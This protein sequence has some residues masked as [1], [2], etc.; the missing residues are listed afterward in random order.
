MSRP[1]LRPRK[2]EPPPAESPA[3]KKAKKPAGKGTAKEKTQPAVEPAV[4]PAVDGMMP[5][6]LPLAESLAPVAQVRKT[7]IPNYFTLR[8]CESVDTS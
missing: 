2:V 4:E 8:R 6:E 3:A 5:P 7:L 1:T